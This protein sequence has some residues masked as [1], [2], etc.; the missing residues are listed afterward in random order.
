LGRTAEAKTTSRVRGARVSDAAAAAALVEDLGY[1]HQSAAEAADRLQ[2]L[3]PD[4]DHLVLV[5]EADRSVVGLIHAHYCIEL[6]VEP[7]VEIMAL[8]VAEPC[9]GL[10][11]GGALTEA[12][13]E[14]AR[15]KEVDEVWVRARVE[16]LRAPAFYGRHGFV[17]DR[18]QNVFV[19]KLGAGSGRP[20]A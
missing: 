2:A 18:Q 5:A 16:R 12:V 8:I 10:G 19:R 20:K 13:A 14:W 1:P 15:G 6:A 3:L 4:G 11:L 9:R 7:F 17:P